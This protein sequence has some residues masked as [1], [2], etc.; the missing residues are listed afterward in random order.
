MAYR[1]PTEQIHFKLKTREERQ[2]RELQRI[3]DLITKYDG[4][5]WA[6]VVRNIRKKNKRLSRERLDNFMSMT[7]AELKANIAQEVTL[8]KVVSMPGD[9]HKSMAS[10]NKEY[11]KTR[12]ALN[13]YEKRLKAR[14]R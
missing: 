5:F 11:S 9:Y 13:E 4:Q 6:E 3:Q 10:L 7:E 8:L 14:G 2:R 12:K 1:K